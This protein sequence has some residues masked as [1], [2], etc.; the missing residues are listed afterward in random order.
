MS[1]EPSSA[2]LHRL[3]NKVSLFKLLM[4]NDGSLHFSLG[5]EATP[6]KLK[7]PN[8]SVDSPLSLFEK[9]LSRQL[10]KHSTGLEACLDATE[11]L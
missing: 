11:S 4:R 10:Q 1:Q 5:L 6:V 9:R 2:S 3:Q 7:P 8:I